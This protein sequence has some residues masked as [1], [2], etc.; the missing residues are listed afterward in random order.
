M[1]E[2]AIKLREE[3]GA[4]AVAD[5]SLGNPCNDPPAEFYEA[6]RAEAEGGPD[7]PHRYM[8]N[9]G[10]PDVREAVAAHLTQRSEVGYTAAD[11][12]MTTGAAGAIN[13]LL[14][15]LLDPGDEVVMCSPG[16]VEYPF[17][18]EN[19]G[20]HSCIVPSTPDF[21]PD[22][23]RIADACNANTKAVILNA[24]NNPTGRIYP[25]RTY[26]ELGR[27]LAARSA[28]LS[29]PIYLIFDD[30]YYEIYYGEQ[31]PPEP[32]QFYD[33]VLYVTSFSKDLGLAGERIGYVAIHPD[34]VHREEL[35]AA[36]AFSL[37]ALGQVN[38]PAL[39]Q[40]ATKA[41]IGLS[42]DAVRD[43]YRPRRDR[44]V[45]ALAAGGFETSPLEGAF[46]A[47]PK[48]PDADDLVFCRR[49]L[50]KGLVVVP[51]AA[52]GTAGHFRI[53]YAVDDDVLERGLAILKAES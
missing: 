52:F 33:Q 26:R 17:Y 11:I 50:E 39:L 43:F 12:C 36:F 15:T 45:E 38:A 51:G 42:R 7:R 16:F 20:G 31:P 14:R 22:V 21:L 1:F 40:R 53:S 3:R 41:L 5:L 13:V 47:F 49:M 19:F 44:V 35:S 23:D 27:A 46:Y 24:P 28:A 8:Q 34:A 2:A 29:R 25:E 6:L 10:Y 48:S 9:P 37:R 32:A 18:V 30:P 4:D